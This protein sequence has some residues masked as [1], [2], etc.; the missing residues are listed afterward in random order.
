MED[1]AIIR[2]TFS[3][4]KIIR[5]RKVCQFI[6]EV[7]LEDGDRSLTTLGG[8]PVGATE[9]WVAVALLDPKATQQAALT[10]SDGKERQSFGSLRYGAQAALK[11][12]ERD[13]QRFLHASSEQGAADAIRV[14]CGVTSRG[15]IETSEPAKA[16]WLR[17]LAEYDQ[18]QGAR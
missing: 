8:L 2:G 15:E 4:F 11:C 10:R 12:K 13:F 1:R 3:D 5:T 16:A 6:V 14:R 7:P 9:R 18:Y 17:T